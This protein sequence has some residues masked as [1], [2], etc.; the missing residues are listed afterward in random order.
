[1]SDGSD[2]LYFTLIEHGS[3]TIIHTIR[4]YEFSRSSNQ[5]VYVKRINELE[6]VH[7]RIV[8]NIWFENRIVVIH[9]ITGAVT[10]SIQFDSP[11]DASTDSTATDAVLN[12]IAADVENG[13]LYITGK[14]WHTIHVVQDRVSGNSSYVDYIRATDANDGIDPHSSSL[15]CDS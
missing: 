5:F 2:T 15:R 7:D 3:M 1:M 11:T 9:P 6:M 14:L 10:K 4:V 12:G 13:K 8:A